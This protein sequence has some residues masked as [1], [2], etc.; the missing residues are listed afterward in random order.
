ME[1]RIWNIQSRITNL[2]DFIVSGGISM[3][4]FLLHN[5]IF[6]KAVMVCCMIGALSQIIQGISYHSMIKA[7]SQIGRT[8]KKWLVSFKKKYEDYD[9]LNVK[10]NN[11]STFA[12]GAFRKKRILGFSLGFWQM[13]SRLCIGG[14]AI[15]GSLGALIYSQNGTDLSQVIYTYLIGSIAA[16]T[17]FMVEL[18]L[19]SD[20]KQERILNNMTDYLENVLKNTLQGR[21]AANDLQ[22]QRNQRRIMD[23]AKQN[24]K[25][26]RFGGKITKEEERILEDVLQEFFA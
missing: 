1:T 12:Q 18:L 7:S 4:D 3:L 14:A 2:L 22:G 13:L 10:I 5:T 8:K 11:V 9:S 16:M 6:I 17:L 26:K 23:Y 25:K 21:N 24:Q 20:K 19:Q 15:A